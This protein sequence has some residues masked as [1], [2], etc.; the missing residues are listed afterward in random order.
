MVVRSDGKV[1][2]L[3]EVEKKNWAPID[4]DSIPPAKVDVAVEVETM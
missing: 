1:F 4:G 3:V 2:C